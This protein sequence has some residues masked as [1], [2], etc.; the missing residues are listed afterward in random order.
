MNSDLEPTGRILGKC[1]H[2]GGD[3]EETKYKASA[4]ASE[5]PPPICNGC[6]REVSPSEIK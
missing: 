5:P 2:C 6:N 1:P 4:V 3:V